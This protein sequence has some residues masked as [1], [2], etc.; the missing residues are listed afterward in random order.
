MDREIT[1]HL[2]AVD[3]GGTG[4]RV[5]VSDPYGKEI[6]RAS[7]GPA[8]V[9]TDRETAIRNLSDAIMS[10]L[11]SA[12]LPASRCV[13][14]AGL[15][16]VL[17]GTDATAVAA[18][19]PFE[20]CT[21]SDDRLTSVSGALGSR[22][23]ALC[24][25]GTG[26]FVATRRGAAITYYG[27]WGLRLGDQASGAWL[28]RAALERALLAHDGLEAQTD[29]T[30]AIL[31]HFGDS[32]ARMVAYGNRAVPGDFASFAPMVL[33]AADAG[34]RSGLTLMRRGADY[35]DACLTVAGIGADDVVCLTGGLGTRYAP[36]LGDAFRDRIR[37]AEGTALDGALLL[38][39]QTLKQMEAL[40]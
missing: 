37:P 34:D 27:G 31:A 40:A 26:T 20:H 17:D 38:A 3:G 1:Y 2:C 7:G 24:S 8:N 16:G 33:D 9:A 25:V 15:A 19:L 5:L 14:H 6:A 4:C 23:G 18:R 29:L 32:P 39:R 35:L 30:H 10:A 36:Y 28:G 21:V 11:G 22:N 13:A 12:N